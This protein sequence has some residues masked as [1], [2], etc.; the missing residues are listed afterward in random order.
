[1]TIEVKWRS[2]T[3][4]FNT[5]LVLVLLDIWGTSGFDGAVASVT[6]QT[7]GENGPFTNP[8]TARNLQLV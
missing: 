5:T 1:M 2:L 3:V 8:W 4:H 7:S 6:T